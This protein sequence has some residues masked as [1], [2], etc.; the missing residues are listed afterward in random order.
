MAQLTPLQKY[1]QDLT[2]DDFSYD[3]AQENAVKHLQ[4]L[5]DDLVV[6]PVVTTGFMNKVKTLFGSKE[7]QQQITGLYFW[8]GVGRGK[9]LFSGYIL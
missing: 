1:Q 4:R 2:R 7:T 3:A 8:G 6:E 5:Y 9:N